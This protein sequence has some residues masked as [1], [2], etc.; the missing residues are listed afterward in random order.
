MQVA[1]ATH[2]FA[3]WQFIDIPDWR[4]RSDDSVQQQ[5][6]SPWHNA[7]SSTRTAEAHSHP[8]PVDPRF[9]ARKDH[10]IVQGSN[11]NQP[12]RFERKE[13]FTRA[14]KEADG[15]DPHRISDWHGDRDH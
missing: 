1:V 7:K 11:S 2:I 15:F 12:S 8:Q 9:G 14:K 5:L 3:R 4:R 6:S 13:A 10:S